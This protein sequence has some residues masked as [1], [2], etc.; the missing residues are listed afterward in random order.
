MFPLSGRAEE[1]IVIGYIVSLLWM[2]FIGS[3]KPVKDYGFKNRIMNL[4]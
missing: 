1:V 4:K 2:L 3:A